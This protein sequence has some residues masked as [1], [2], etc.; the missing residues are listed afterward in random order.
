M[1]PKSG[2]ARVLPSD[3]GRDLVRR[4]G[5]AFDA[6]VVNATQGVPSVGSVAL[7]LHD[8]DDDDGVSGAEGLTKTRCMMSDERFLHPMSCSVFTLSSA[9]AIRA[10]QYWRFPQPKGGSSQNS[11]CFL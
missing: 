11:P 4:G 3:R 1:P 9:P 7:G 6:A 10:T 2:R 8:D 5:V